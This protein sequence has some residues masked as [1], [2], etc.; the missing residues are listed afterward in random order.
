[1]GILP[2]PVLHTHIGIFRLVVRFGLFRCGVLGHIQRLPVCAHNH[3]VKLIPDFLTWEIGDVPPAT[4]DRL[5]VMGS[6][7]L[8]P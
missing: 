8:G 2:A 5:C 4:G 3:F 7:T 1:M 6:V